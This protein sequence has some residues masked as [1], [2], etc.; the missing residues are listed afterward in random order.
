MQGDEI[1]MQGKAKG[2]KGR[3]GEAGGGR[4]AGYSRGRLGMCVIYAKKVGFRQ[5]ANALLSLT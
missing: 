4:V 5:D 2:C 3:Q 1:R